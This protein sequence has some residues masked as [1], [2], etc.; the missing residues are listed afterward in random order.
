M[1]I[2]FF[3]SVINADD[4]WHVGDG[5]ISTQTKWKNDSSKTLCDVGNFKSTTCNIEAASNIYNAKTDRWVIWAH[6]ENGQDY[7]SSHLIVL[8][9][10]SGDPK[11]EYFVIWNGRAGEGHVATCLEDPTFDSA[12]FVEGAEDPRTPGLPYLDGKKEIPAT[13]YTYTHGETTTENHYPWGYGNRDCSTFIDPDTQEGY[14]IST[15]DHVTM[16]MYTLSDDYLNVDW[17]NSYP[18]AQGYAREAPHLTKAAGL[19]YL[20]TSGQ[21][22][23]MPNQAKYQTSTLLKKPANTEEAAAEGV[24]WDGDEETWADATWSA[25]EVFGSC[26]TYN[27]QPAWIE[28][29]MDNTDPQNPVQQFVYHGS[30]WDIDNFENSTNVSLPLLLDP[31]ARTMRMPYVEGWKISNTGRIVYSNLELV[32]EGKKAT[33]TNLRNDADCE[34][35]SC[36]PEGAVNGEW[37]VADNWALTENFFR[38]KAA[39]YEWVLDLEE[40]RVIDRLDIQYWI[41]GGSEGYV[42]STIYGGLDG[43]YWQTID[44]TNARP[45]LGFRSFD[46]KG[47]NCRFIKIKV[48]SAIALHNHNNDVSGWGSGLVEVAVWA[49]PK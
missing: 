48:T 38:P 12:A 17:Q 27:S 35:A 40:V 4:V 37:T 29:V 47:I 33:G 45:Q 23:W 6:W 44:D 20:I 13:C 46:G 22:G 18:F 1:S 28:I 34:T 5:V 10:S 7:S 9:S 19:Y 25:P 42:Y 32:S 8:Q 16:R 39:P 11:S 14:L 43:E 36:G 31:K 30:R 49:Q 41:V 21:S 2:L 24:V 15:Q 26:T 3:L